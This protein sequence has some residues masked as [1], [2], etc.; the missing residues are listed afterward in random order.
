MERL[1]SFTASRVRRLLV[2]EDELAEQLS[3]K[4]G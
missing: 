2:V 1:K 3:V 4:R